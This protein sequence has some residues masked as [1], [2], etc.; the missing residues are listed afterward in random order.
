MSK[1]KQHA[2]ECKA[3]VA[4]DAL[5]GKATVSTLAGR[6]GAHPTMINQGK[7]VLPG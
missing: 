2:P 1:R 5:K 7:R 4:F 3:K 6:F